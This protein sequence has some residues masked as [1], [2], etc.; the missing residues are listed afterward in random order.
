[1]YS[2]TYGK[3]SDEKMIELIGDFIEKSPDS[4]YNI[5]VGTDS[6]NFKCTKTVVVVA[7]HR[8]GN[9]GIFFYDIKRVE[10]I[11]NLS[12]KLF[13]E[14]SIS[15]DIATKLSEALEKE[16]IDFGISIHVDAGKLGQ[17][18]KLIPEIVGWIKACGF[19]CETK[20]NSYAASSI[21]DKYTKT[22]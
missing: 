6:Q 22:P 4:S 1:M 3:I 13:F 7:I 16:E 15:L 18:S 11:N 17:S 19:G 9:G 8:V 14:T 20:P 10:K 12:Q 2:P 21:A 5:S